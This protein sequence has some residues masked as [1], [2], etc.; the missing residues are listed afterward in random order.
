MERPPGFFRGSELPRLL[1]LAVIMVVGWALVWHFAHKMPPP[2][3]PELVATA[4]PEP[5]VAD[6]SIEFET[7]TDRTPIEFRDNAAY[8]LLLQRARGE[9]AGRAGGRR[10]AATSSCRISGKTRSTT[11]ACRSTCWATA[12]RVLRYLRSS[13][14]P[15]GSTRRGSSRRKT[16]RVP[17]ACVFEEAP[18]G[19]PIGTDVSERVVF[20]GYFLKIM[21]YQ[22]A[23][24]S[25]GAP[26]AGRPDR[27]GPS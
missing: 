5:V 11:A 13:V 4:K 20:N 19:F 23:D 2:A 16:T 24:V 27:L 7:V 21:K 22:A 10:A 17:Y 14:R 15:A 8:A 26:R 3:E 12:Q 6:R 18:P 25:R 1:I 9:N